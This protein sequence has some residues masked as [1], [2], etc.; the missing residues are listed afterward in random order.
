VHRVEPVVSEPS[1]FEVEIAIGKVERYKS[2][3][4]DQF[5]HTDQAVG[6]TLNSESHKLIW[7]K[8]E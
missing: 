7:N 1:S 6:K 2:S 8:E 4:T 5:W 3:C